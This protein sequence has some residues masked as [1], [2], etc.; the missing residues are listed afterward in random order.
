MSLK[1]RNTF[2]SHPQ[3][4]HFQSCNQAS[5]LRIALHRGQL[6]MIMVFAPFAAILRQERKSINARRVN[7]W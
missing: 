7:V 2:Y 3:L 4:S 5:F 1:I 6:R